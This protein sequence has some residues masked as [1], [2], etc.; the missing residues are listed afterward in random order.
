M[1]ITD[2]QY[3]DWLSDNS[4][5]RCV[6]IEAI[7]LTGGIETTHYVSSRA[8]ANGSTVYTPVL[9]GNSVRIVESLSVDS[10]G[11]SFSAGDIE[12]NNGDGA[13]DSWITSTVWA[14]R[15]IT[16]LIGDVRWARADFRTIFNG[17]IADVGSRSRNTLNFSIKDKLERLNNPV[18][19]SVLGGTTNNKNELLPLTFGECHNVSLLQTNPATLEYQYHTSTCESVIEVRDNGVPISSTPT[20]ST[21]KL[22]LLAAPYGRITASI[23]GDKAA[24]VYNNTAKKIVQRLVTG[25][26]ETTSRFSTGDLDTSSLTTFDAA[27]PQILGL[28]I[29]SSETVKSACDMVADSVGAQV[30][31]S[32]D[33]LLKLIKVALP[34]TGT[35]FALTTQHI[36]MDSLYIKSKLEIKAGHTIGY[37]KNWTVQEPLD[38]RIPADHKDLFAKEWLTAT[39]SDATTKTNYRLMDYPE[40]KDTFLLTEANATTE[41][42]RLLTLYK[43]PRFVVAFDGFAP[44]LELELGQPVTLTYPRFGLDSGIDGMVV[45]LSPDWGSFRVGVEVLI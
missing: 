44:L 24:G 17:I 3:T 8:Y 20:L 43:S 9:I 40:Q 32:R 13:L 7:G 29:D 22:V 45:G 27:N 12:L 23:Q 34:A 11:G 33:G 30:V 5:A 39:A 28:F 21:G 4:A 2:Q 42:N 25:Y 10:G 14:N 1:A 6:L 18:S 38:T 15:T 16:A 31:M 19:E 35:N 37:C 26:G 41:A 36:V